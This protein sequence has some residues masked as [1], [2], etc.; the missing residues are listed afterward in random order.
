MKYLNGKTTTI[1]TMNYNN[2][3][4]KKTTIQIETIP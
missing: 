2:F 4:E 3:T 1:K